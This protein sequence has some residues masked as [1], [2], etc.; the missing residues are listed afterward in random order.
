MALPKPSWRYKPK[1]NQRE[2]ERTQVVLWQ[3]DGPH[4]TH[5]SRQKE[6]WYEPEMLGD[7]FQIQ[8]RIL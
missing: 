6:V 2:R 8:P 7:E 1:H 4:N 5:N 3:K